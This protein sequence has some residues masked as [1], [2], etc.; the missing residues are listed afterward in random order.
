MGRGSSLRHTGAAG[1]ALVCC[2]ALATPAAAATTTAPALRDG[3]GLHIVA[4]RRLDPRLLAL[5]VTTP[6]LPHPANIR[7]LL[8]TGYRPRARRRYPVLY[9]LHGTSGGAADWTTKGDA[10]KTTAGRP[11]IVAMPDVALD[12][13]G[14]GWC[15]DWVNGGEGGPPEWERFHIRQVMPWVDHNLRTIASRDGRAI[16]GLSQGGFCSMS[17]AARHPDLFSAAL[18]YSGAP[19]TS[20]DAT[21]VAGSTA[22][23]N[24]T[25][26]ALDGAPPNAMFGSRV[27]SE[28]N[29][30]A[31][32]PTTLAA[33]LRGMP[34]WL[35]AGNGLPGPL[36]SGPPNPGAMAIEAAAGYDTGLFHDRLVKL[37]IPSTYV[38][39]GRGTHAWPYWTRDLRE[40]IGPLMD[41]FRHPPARPR[42]LTFTSADTT[43]R[44]AGWHVAMQRTAREFS[45]L[46]DAGRG[47]FAI[48]GSGVAKVTTAARFAAR[49]RYAVT[50]VGDRVARKTSTVRADRHGRLTLT[51]PLGPPNPFQQ[52]TVQAAVAGTK[53]FTTRVTI[54]RRR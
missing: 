45:T 54:T 29:W 39:Y 15:T 52:D 50:R 46:K 37:G 48:A 22:I 13:G 6:A 51:V 38:A 7:I 30:A 43:Y 36:D 9:L 11:L 1:A 21:A 28:V 26:V 41:A 42:L 16:A 18:S 53:V 12:D 10:E 49:R 24:A 35:Y 34:L 3:S 47:G 33:N 27:T 25:E 20:Y 19:D 2:A 40:S 31:H 8:P 5:T 32:D 17:Y 4:Q 14:G 44:I 23:A